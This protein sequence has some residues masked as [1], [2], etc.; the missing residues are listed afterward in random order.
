M[1]K[2]SAKDRNDGDEAVLHHVLDA[3]RL[4]EQE[5]A[6]DE[7]QYG[8]Q[9]ALFLIAQVHFE[10]SFLKYMPRLHGLRSCSRGVAVE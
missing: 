5:N 10:L 7:E 9:D 3:R 8:G 4:H 1:G 2:P 6:E